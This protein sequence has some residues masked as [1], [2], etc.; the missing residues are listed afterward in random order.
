MLDSADEKKIPINGC[1]E[2]LPLCNMRCKMCY[3]R[4]DRG[5][6][7]K[8]G[9]LRTAAEWLE[10]GKQMQEAG[11]LFV[12]LTGGEPLLYPEFKEVYL[13]LKKL[14]MILTINTN[15]TLLDEEWADFFAQHKPRRINITLYGADDEA[16]KT[17]C[18]YPGGYSKAVNAIRML[19]ERKVDVRMGTSVTPV[20]V[21]DIDRI[22]AQAQELKCPIIMDTYMMPGIRERDMDYPQNARLSPTDA[23]RARIKALKGEMG[24]ALFAQ[25]ATGSIEQVNGFRGVDCET[26]MSCHAGN[27]SYVINWQGN[28]RP[29]IILGEPSVSVFEEGF[30]PAW[31]KI[32]EAC[33]SIKRCAKCNSCNLRPICR[34]CVASCML[35]SGS[36]EGV[37][38]YMCRYAEESYRLL[39]LEAERI[40]ND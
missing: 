24:S 18:S 19:R 21:G 13:G 2:L 34:T 39:K 5:D 15:G 1:I 8:K 26:G 38:E 23:A 20:N 14:G 11:T 12:L 9:R 3:V 25:Y 22:M 10:I 33:D 29:C 40:N 27:C 17:L 28:L 35:E 30:M 4:M 37:P 32:V 31:K 7:E 6:M 36:Y 16:Y